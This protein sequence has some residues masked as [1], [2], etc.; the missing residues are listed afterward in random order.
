M[1]IIE[2]EPPHDERGT[3]EVSKGIG[4]REREGL[5]ALASKNI[6]AYLLTGFPATAGSSIGSQRTLKASPVILPKHS[7]SRIS[8]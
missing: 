7:I 4:C 1:E 5:E 8:F 3:S 6:R 2:E